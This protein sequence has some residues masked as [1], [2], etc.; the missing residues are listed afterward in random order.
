MRLFVIPRCQKQIGG[1]WAFNR[2]AYIIWKHSYHLFGLRIA[3]FIFDLFAKGLNWILMNAGWMAIHYL[4]HFLAVL[5]EADRRWCGRIRRNFCKDLQGF[6]DFQP[7]PRKMLEGLWLNFWAP[8]SILS[9]W[10]LDYLKITWRKP[11]PGSRKLSTHERFPEAIFDLFL[12][13][14]L[15]LVR[16]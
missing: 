1:F 4:D 15:L 11:E 16:W 14:Y 12:A 8:K 3:P 13:F 5:N 6:W 10:K 9:G 7:I 2:R